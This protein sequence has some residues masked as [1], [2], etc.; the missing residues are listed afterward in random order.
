ME[1]GT[2]RI[3]KARTR[4]KLNSGDRKVPAQGEGISKKEGRVISSLNL[5]LMTAV[6]KSMGDMWRN[7]RKA[8]KKHLQKMKKLQRG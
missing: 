7:T 3:S 1:G 2:Q 4:V 8:N 6:L 5:A